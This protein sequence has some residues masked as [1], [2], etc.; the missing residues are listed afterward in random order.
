MTAQLSQSIWWQITICLE[1]WQVVQ[2]QEC[3]DPGWTITSSNQSS[4]QPIFQF[5]PSLQ[6]GNTCDVH[7]TIHC[8]CEI[9]E[10]LHSIW[11][12]EDNIHASY[13]AMLWKG[14]LKILCGCQADNFFKG[15]R[16]ANKLFLGWNNPFFSGNF[17]NNLFIS[18]KEGNNLFILSKMGN[19]LFISIFSSTPPPPPP[20]H[21]YQMVRP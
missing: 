4:R 15:I 11:T 16:P 8:K 21:R 17:K 13:I 5:A 18:S 2:S 7:S 20:P 12:M 10:I 14:L 9:N 1:Q 6:L 19:I 3:T